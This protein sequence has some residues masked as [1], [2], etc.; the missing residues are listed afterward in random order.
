[1]ERRA[2]V[3][4]AS[5][6]SSGRADAVLSRHFDTPHTPERRPDPLRPHREPEE[7]E[8][9]EALLRDLEEIIF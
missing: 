9:A 7:I 1:M 3:Q 8:D 4:T 6:L 2:D 5:S